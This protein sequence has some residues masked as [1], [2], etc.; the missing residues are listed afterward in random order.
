M[1]ALWTTTYHQVAGDDLKDLGLE[2]CSAGKD[3]LEDA[4][5]SMA[6]RGA[7]EGAINGHLGYSGAEVMAIL[8]EVVSQ[9]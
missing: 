4:D 5:K 8:A 3:P 7:D 9:P 2:T 6:H 1:V